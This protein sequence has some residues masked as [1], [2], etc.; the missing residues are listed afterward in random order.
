[1]ILSTCH[2]KIKW[3][4]SDI[5]YHLEKGSLLCSHSAMWSPIFTLHAMTTEHICLIFHSNTTNK[6]EDKQSLRKEREKNTKSVYLTYWRKELGLLSP[7]KE[8]PLCITHAIQQ[9][10]TVAYTIMYHAMNTP[11][12]SSH[13]WPELTEVHWSQYSYQNI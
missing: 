3:K 5:I 4:I 10:T 9:I 11:Q 8:F 12:Q 2:I 6:R 13:S 7:K 1:M